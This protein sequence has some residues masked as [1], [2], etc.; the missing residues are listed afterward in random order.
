MAASS[1]LSPVPG[2][3]PH[4]EAFKLLPTANVPPA[5]LVESMKAP[6]QPPSAIDM[7]ME[8]KTTT[9]TVACHDLSSNIKHMGPVEYPWRDGGNIYFIPASEIKKSKQ[10][11]LSG[12]RFAAACGLVPEWMGTPEDMA[13]DML[14]KIKKP[15]SD[16]F[17]TQMGIIGEPELVKWYD[18]HIAVT[19]EAFY[20]RP[21]NMDFIAALADRVVGE[22][23]ILECK[24]KKRIPQ[25]LLEGRMHMN[26][27]CQVQTE[28]YC[29]KRKWCDYLVYGIED[30]AI[31]LRRHYHDWTFWETIARPRAYT[32]Y[33]RYL[34]P[35]QPAQSE[36]PAS[37]G[38][39]EQK[40]DD[41]QSLQSLQSLQT[42]V[43]SST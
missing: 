24:V 16:P 6:S 10:R 31:Y 9:P 38:P 43:A 1:A 29:Y 14:F 36:L 23:G 41:K 7:A 30:N 19:S 22:E 4:S 32:F 13:N 12:Y 11:L 34:Q 5:N 33:F 17:M 26:D 21:K 15:V 27:F 42:L 8:R 28:I 25:V 2:S 40:S 35:A 37:Q 3:G 20:A 18:E 39:K